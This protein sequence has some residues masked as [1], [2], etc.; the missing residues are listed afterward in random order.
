MTPAEFQTEWN[1]GT[2]TTLRDQW[3]AA[4][5][6]ASCQAVLDQFNAIEDNT[7]GADCHAVIDFLKAELPAVIAEL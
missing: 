1:S 3:K 5:T 2:P 4:H 6:A 7:L